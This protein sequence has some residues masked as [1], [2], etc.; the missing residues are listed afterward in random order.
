MNNKILNNITPGEILEEEFLKPLGITKYKLAKETQIT[1][2]TVSKIVSGERRITPEVALKI[3]K[4]L[5]VTPQFWLNLQ[6]TYDLRIARKH[7]RHK[8]QKIAKYASLE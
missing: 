1:P 7:M 4:F 8:L 3:G 5:D 6:N 2:I